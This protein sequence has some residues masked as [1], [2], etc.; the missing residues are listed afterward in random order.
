MKFDLEQI[1][2]ACLAPLEG[3]SPAG[4]NARYE[5]E[6]EEVRGEISKLTALTAGGEEVNW[7]LIVADSSKL[8]A[9]TSKDLNLAVYLCLGLLRHDQYPGLLAGLKVFSGLVDDFWDSA[10]PPARRG[11]ARVNVYQWLDDRVGEAAEV[12]EPGADQAQALHECLEIAQKL[13]NE[14]GAKVAA[15]VTGLSTLRHNL[16]NW[17]QKYPLAPPPEPEPEPAAPSETREQPA[18]S[19]ADGQTGAAKPAPAA[20]PPPP[21]PA[22]QAESAQPMQQPGSTSQALNTLRPFI[23]SLR[24]LDPASPL[25][26]ALARVAKWQLLIEAPDAGSDGTTQVPGPRDDQVGGLE[27]LAKAGNQKGLT[28]EAEALFLAPPGTFLLDLQRQVAQGL[29]DQGFDQAAQVV[30]EHTG[31]LLNRLPALAGMSFS[32]GRPFADPQT[33][34]WLEKARAA[35]AGPALEAAPKEEWRA[36]ALA[37]ASK[38]DLAQSMRTM[39]NAVDLAPDMAEA[40]RRRLAAVELCLD[41]QRPDWALPILQHMSAQ[42]ENLTLQQ[43]EPSFCARIWA[44]IL[45][46]YQSMHGPETPPDEQT[47]KQME[48]AKRKLF[49]CDLSLAA[50]FSQDNR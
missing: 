22:R 13:A 43:W 9:K 42:M 45:R 24:G 16:E 21:P 10:F 25:P 33:K 11:K 27:A 32:T 41:Y 39:Q 4:I 29:E 36:E 20:T 1:T 46:A 50:Q 48:Q 49:E 31:K 3:D 14:V 35:A 8:L 28:E 34:A 26:Y 30:L 2:T 15:P 37:L 44:G 7:E 40:F 23:H 19:E 38:G 17:C 47:R 5:S 12:V 18:P 6:Y